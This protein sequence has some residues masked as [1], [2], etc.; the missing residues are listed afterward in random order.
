MSLLWIT[1]LG[2]GLLLSGL[3]SGSE[4]AL[5]SISRTRVE[6]EAV[7]GSRRAAVIRSLLRHEAW[8]LA[9][10]LLANNIVNQVLAVATE[11]LIDPLGVP[12]LYQELV[13]ALTITPVLVLLGELFPKDLARRRPHTL[14]GLAAPLLAVV[15]L[16][17]SPLT[18]PLQ[19]FTGTLS[20]LLG[21]QADELSRVQGRERVLELLR[22]RD[23]RLQPAI[24]RLA[25]NV[26]ELRTRHVERVMIPWKRVEVLRLER[27]SEEALAQFAVS[28]YTRLPVLDRK[29]AVAG[30]IH[31][32][33][34]LGGPPGAPLEGL[35]RPLITLDPGTP[36]DRA[37][38][39]L[40]ASGQ[41]A[42]LVGSAT[43]P[44]GWV[45]LKD[46][47]EEISGE[48]ARW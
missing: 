34:L 30:Y 42:A 21:L 47:V 1:V 5:Y 32:L 24:E 25:H 17:L 29:G 23:S 19:L 20:R 39:R 31:Q 11:G 45:T 16:L 43:R 8:L 35:L 44:L 26:L 38:A 41:R 2:V 10:L 48:L 46:L 14:L 6:A 12:E 28:P 7:H 27:S 40:R 13:V 33:E 3:F 4:I 15:R 18:L 36:L 22:E 37:L 9:T